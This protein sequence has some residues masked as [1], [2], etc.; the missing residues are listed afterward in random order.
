[1]AFCIS[2]PSDAG[3]VKARDGI[4][5]MGA[6][7]ETGERKVGIQAY[8]N[9]GGTAESRRFSSLRDESGFLFLRN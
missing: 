5:D 2:R 9:Q 7:I 8:A 3:R 4:K 6:L 1:M